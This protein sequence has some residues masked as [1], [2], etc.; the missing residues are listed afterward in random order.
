MV[1]YP[2]SINVM[3][4][5][6]KR[7]DKNNM[8]ISIDTQKASDKIQHPFGIKTL[9][10]ICIEGICLHMIKVI[11]DKPTAYITL[12]GEKLKTF[13]LKLGTRMPILTICS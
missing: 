13:L 10:K 12:S 6:N 1:Q 9:N 8:N 4:H 11:Y 7:K 5:I 3:H 2:K